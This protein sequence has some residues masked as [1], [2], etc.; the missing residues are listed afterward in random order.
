MHATCAVCKVIKVLQFFCLNPG[1]NTY[2][3]K[4]NKIVSAWSAIRNTGQYMPQSVY[5]SQNILL[6]MSTIFKEMTF[7]IGQEITDI[8][9]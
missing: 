5:T 8:T 9:T 2:T 3:D 6:F 1:Y 7:N 4:N